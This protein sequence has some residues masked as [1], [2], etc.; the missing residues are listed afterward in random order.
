MSR[1]LLISEQRRG[2]LALPALI[3]LPVVLLA[4]VLGLSARQFS[5]IHTRMQN[6]ADAGTL[7]GADALM[8]DSL[9]RGRYE[10]G[11]IALNSFC[12]SSRPAWKFAT[13]LRSMLSSAV[14]RHPIGIHPL[15]QRL[16]FNSA[17]TIRLNRPHLRPLR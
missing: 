16:I 10:G 9:L 14:I 1:T 8:G 2:G 7:A 11:A 3:A 5:D 4:F 17:R 13:T 15:Q 12:C 6:E